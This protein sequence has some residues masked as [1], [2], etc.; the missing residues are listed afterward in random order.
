MADTGGGEIRFCETIDLI[1]IQGEGLFIW[2]TIWNDAMSTGRTLGRQMF[3]SDV[4]FRCSVQGRGGTSRNLGL[5]VVWRCCCYP[6][7]GRLPIS[8]TTKAFEGPNHI[9]V[10]LD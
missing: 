6:Y 10:S 1:Q 4:R 7:Q 3:G 5:P 9:E 2:E 8:L